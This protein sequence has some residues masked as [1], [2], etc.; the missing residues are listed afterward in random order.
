MYVLKQYD[1][2]KK[3]PKQILNIHN[4]RFVNVLEIATQ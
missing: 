1:R 3:R 4:K 2:K